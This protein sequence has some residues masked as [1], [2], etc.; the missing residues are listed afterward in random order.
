MLKVVRSTKLALSNVSIV[1]LTLDGRPLHYR[2]EMNRGGT[3]DLL[4]RLPSSVREGLS[5]LLDVVLRPDL[6]FRVGRDN[7]AI[8][9]GH[10][11]PAGSIKMLLAALV[12]GVL[13]ISIDDFVKA[14]AAGICVAD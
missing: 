6:S 11:G 9:G 1:S 14:V 4:G 13:G 3:F 8:F 12:A 5:D 2:A 7:S 10:I